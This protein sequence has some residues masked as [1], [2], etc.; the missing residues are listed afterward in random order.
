MIGGLSGVVQLEQIGV[1]KKYRGR[2]IGRKLIQTAENFW[3]KYFVNEYGKPLYKMLLTTSKINDDA[4]NL[5]SAAGFKYE[6]TMK[7]IYWNND[8]EIWVKEF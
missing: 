5:Y 6:T 1:L 3:E 2:G 4:H 8:E 7:K